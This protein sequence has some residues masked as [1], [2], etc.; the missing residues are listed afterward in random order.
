MDIVKYSIHIL[1]F[2]STMWIWKWSLKQGF[3]K[4]FIIKELESL[5][6]GLGDECTKLEVSLSVID[7]EFDSKNKRGQG[8]ILL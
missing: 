1:T 3:R 8:L 5:C 6:L 2:L 4:Y 7:C